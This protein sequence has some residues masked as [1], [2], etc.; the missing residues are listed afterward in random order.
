MSSPRG[1]STAAPTPVRR[2][3]TSTETVGRLVE[4]AVDEIRAEGYDGLT[5][6]GVARR[7]GVAPATAYTYFASKDHLV[8]EAFWRRLQEVP[9]VGGDDLDL[10]APAERVVAA[11][12]GLGDLVAAEPALARASTT[13]VLADEPDVAAVRERIGAFVHRRISTALGPEAD[14]AV[15]RALQLTWSGAMVLAGTGNIAYTDVPDRVSEVAG[16][17]LDGRQG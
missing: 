12:G 5:V 1:A 7:A 13:A 15:L 6:R 3:A 9:P 4:A 11:L 8:A 10:V 14:P 2:T 16:L 17:V